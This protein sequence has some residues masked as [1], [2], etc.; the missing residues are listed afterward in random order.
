MMFIKNATGMAGGW[1]CRISLR[2]CLRCVLTAGARGPGVPPPGRGNLDGLVH[3][4]IRV[5]A[6]ELRAS[7]R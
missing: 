5:R 3:V 2:T 4:P 6:S 1:V 7:R